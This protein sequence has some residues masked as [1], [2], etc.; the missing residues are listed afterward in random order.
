MTSSALFSSPVNLADNFKGAIH[1]FAISLQMYLPFER[2]IKKGGFLEYAKVYDNYY[3]TP[4]SFVEENLMAGRDL[5]LEIDI[6][7]RFE[8]KRTIR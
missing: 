3:G 1:F 7:R 2:L 8:G 5:I 4:K 6:P